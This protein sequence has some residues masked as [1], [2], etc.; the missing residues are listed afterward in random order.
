[1]ASSRKDSLEMRGKEDAHYSVTIIFY[2][3]HYDFRADKIPSNL[4]STYIQACRARKEKMLQ[5]KRTTD[6]LTITLQ[7]C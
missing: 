7:D 5:G 3:F 6:L 2:F 4:Y 1:M